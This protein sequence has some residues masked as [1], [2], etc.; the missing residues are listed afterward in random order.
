[1]RVLDFIE[2]GEQRIESSGQLSV[3][4]S[5]QLWSLPASQHAFPLPERSRTEPHLEIKP[6]LA[7][8]NTLA[9]AVSNH[10]EVRPGKTKSELPLV[11]FTLMSQMAAGMAVFS[12]F[13]GPL[14]IPLLLAIGMLIGTGGLISFLH[15]GRPLNAWR[16]VFHLRKSWLSRE[17]LM[18][19]LFGGSWL[20]SLVMPGTGKLPLALCG[21]GLAYSMVKVYRLRS[22]P[23]W[24]TNRTLLAFFVSPVLL[25]G[26]GLVAFDV[27]RNDAIKMGYLLAGGAGLVGALLLSLSD[28]N[29]VH[30]TARRFRLGLIVLALAGVATMYLVPDSIGRWLAV[31]IFV[32]VLVEEVIGRWL[33]YEHLHQRIL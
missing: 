27:V 20:V 18:F 25:G 5:Y 31:P 7:M 28:R 6:H 14:S 11:A 1:M 19:G 9:K 10:E 24:D 4:S 16:A 29:Q 17:I 13:S 2:I 8:T 26:L 15:L 30:H 21:I 32:I 33:F 22:V 23:A 12:L 3:T